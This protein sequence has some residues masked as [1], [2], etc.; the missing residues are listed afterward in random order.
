[1]PT[2]TIRRKLIYLSG[3]IQNRLHDFIPLVVNYLSV[4][5]DVVKQVFVFQMSQNASVEEDGKVKVVQPLVEQHD[6]FDGK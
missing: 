3:C 5:S 6:V 4:T 1:M 2:S